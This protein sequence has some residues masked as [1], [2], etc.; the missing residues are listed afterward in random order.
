MERF[1]FKQALILAAF[2]GLLFLGIWIVTVIVGMIPA[3]LLAA[4]VVVIGVCGIGVLISN[5]L[6]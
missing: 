1:T 4:A 5:S 6:G 3:N 2:Y